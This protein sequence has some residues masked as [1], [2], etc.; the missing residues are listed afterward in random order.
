MERKPYPSDVSNDE[1]AFVAPYLTLM[2]EDAPQR[3]HSLREVFNGLRWIVRAGAAWRMMPHDLP[4]W[5]TVYQQSQRW[6][7]AGVFETMVIDL[8]E[9]LRM[10][11]GRNPQPSAAIFDSR[12]LQSTPE[13]GWRAGFDPAKSRRGSKVHL[14]VD[15][16]GYL[17]ALLVTP[18]NEQDRHQVAELTQQVQEVTGDSVELAFVDQAYTGEQAAQDAAANHIKLEVVKRPEANSGFVLL[19]RRW[20]VERSQG[21]MARFRR[22]ARDYEQLAET[23]KGLH[24]VAFAMLML[25]QLTELILQSA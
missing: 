11:Q 2:T 23:L 16:L 15:T 3:E 10:A 24:V 19:P 21:W 4:P 12:T 7:K 13:S 25:R 6:F 22:L 14:A 5:Y 18:A 8:R 20:V 17:L 9:L 1:W